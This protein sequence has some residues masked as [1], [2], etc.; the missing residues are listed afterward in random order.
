MD[1]HADDTQ[2]VLQALFAQPEADIPAHPG[3]LQRITETC[4]GQARRC[5]QQLRGQRLGV[6]LHALDEC[7]VSRLLGCGDLSTFNTALADRQVVAILGQR[8]GVD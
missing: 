8:D 6:A 7:S 1:I 2:E 3:Q 5:F 4:V